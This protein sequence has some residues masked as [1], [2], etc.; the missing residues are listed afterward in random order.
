MSPSNSD[1]GNFET[2][3]DEEEEEEEEEGARK[4]AWDRRIRTVLLQKTYTCRFFVKEI[5]QRNEINLN[6]DSLTNELN[7]RLMTRR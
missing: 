6:R 1:Y 2:S 5:D 7:E 4:L 3:S